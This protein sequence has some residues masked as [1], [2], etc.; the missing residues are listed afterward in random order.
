MEP[1][2]YLVFPKLRSRVFFEVKDYHAKDGIIKAEAI[3]C[4]RSGDELE[5]HLGVKARIYHATAT[6]V[7]ESFANG[8]QNITL[9]DAA[10]IIGR[11]GVT[12][13][14]RVV[15]AGTGSGSL[16]AFL[17]LYAGSVSSFE[18]REDFAQ[19]ARTNLDRLAIIGLGANI[20][21]HTAPFEDAPKVLSEKQDIAILD[22]PEPWTCYAP[23]R[24]VL[25]DGGILVCYVPNATQASTCAHRAGE[26]GFVPLESVELIR[27]EWRFSERIAKPGKEVLHTAF[28]LFFR[29]TS[30]Q[31]FK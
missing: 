18:L 2:Y 14:S 10:Y 21:A 8:P 24:E 20:A 17:S 3:G 5:T 13:E 22:M 19:L 15:E 31:T 6:D 4:A 7:I 25:R 26:H 30:S 28:L 27:R 29:K 9:K 1:P 12:R 16:T 23:A 11:C